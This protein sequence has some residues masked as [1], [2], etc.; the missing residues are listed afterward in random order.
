M[1]EATLK[2]VAKL[3]GV[4]PITVSRVANGSEHVA[5]ATREKILAIIRDLDYTPNIHA[6][7]LSRKRSNGESSS[8]PKIR[9]VSAH[10]RLR[11][12]CNSWV[13]PLHPRE[14]TLSFSPEE[15]RSLAQQIIQL[16]RDVDRLRKQ[17]ERIQTCAEIIQEA[18]SRRLS[19][20]AAD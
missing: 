10:E 2:F 16:R 3:A 18:C 12:G 15:A 11:S 5:A 8:G 13:N 6:A 17:T 9:S 14:G 20:C 4:A 19:S 1:P 7:S